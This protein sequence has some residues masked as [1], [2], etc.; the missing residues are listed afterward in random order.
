L[1]GMKTNERL[2]YVR[3][4]LDIS[5]RDI[6]REMGIGRSTYQYMELGLHGIRECYYNLFRYTFG[7]N[8][9]WL[10]YGTGEMILQTGRREEMLK[11]IEQLTN[12]P[13]FT[14][15]SKAKKMKENQNIRGYQ[16]IQEDL[17][18]NLLIGEKHI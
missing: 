1:D 9:E 15:L 12:E 16:E 14:L 18:K 5:Q 11:M 2:L 6:A 13:F 8:S 17:C 7:I 4:Y 3:N 10:K